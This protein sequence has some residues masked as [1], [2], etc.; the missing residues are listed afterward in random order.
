MLKNLFAVLSFIFI[1][2][3]CLPLGNLEGAVFSTEKSSGD[4][5][6]GKT[7]KLENY[8]QID[9]VTI[10]L[11]SGC[12]FY[13]TV[14]LLSAKRVHYFTDGTVENYYFFSEKLP[15]SEMINGKKVNF[16]VAV[17]NGKV[18]VGSPIIYYGY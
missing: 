12:N 3:F 10:S 2:F 9:G 5:I 15:K 6:G 1:M 16:H 18:T 13:D 4:F 14:E 7:L 11:P 8:F 17:S